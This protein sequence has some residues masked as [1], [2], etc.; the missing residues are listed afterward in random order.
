MDKSEFQ[1]MAE[2]AVKSGRISVP[3]LMN[4]AENRKQS[5]Q[6]IFQAEPVKQRRL[7]EKGDVG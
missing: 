1:Q 4:Y 2:A 6:D 5:W 3:E 7:F